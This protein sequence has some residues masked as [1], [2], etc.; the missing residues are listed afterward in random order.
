MGSGVSTLG[1]AYSYGNLLLELFTGKR[2]THE[3]FNDGLNIHNFAERALSGQLEGIIDPVILEEGQQM[4]QS[5]SYHRTQASTSNRTRAST[6][7]RV[8]ECLISILRVGLTC[9]N[10]QPKE[11]MDISDAVAELNSIRN[12][13]L[14]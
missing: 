6:S 11:R 3:M 1:D 7:N 12:K 4:D 2:P 14:Q 10:E 8:Q 13:L 9:S 5:S